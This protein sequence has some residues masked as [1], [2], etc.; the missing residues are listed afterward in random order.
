M[1]PV[2][3]T[4]APCAITALDANALSRSI[5]SRQL[6][7]REVMQAGGAAVAQ[8]QRLLPVANGSDFMG[9]L[10]NPAGWNHVPGFRP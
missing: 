3:P 8:A 2:L 10:R 7:C 1:N 9:S 5:H 4:P 6:S